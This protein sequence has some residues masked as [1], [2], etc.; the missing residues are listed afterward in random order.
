MYSLTNLVDNILYKRGAFL[1]KSIC[2]KISN[3]STTKYLLNQLNSFDFP[4]VY[5]SCKQFKIY[6]NII[7]HF[8]GKNESLFFEK[9]SEMLSFL[10]INLFEEKIIKY[11]LKSE[12]FY[13]EEIEQN[14]IANIVSEDLY[15]EEESIY[16]FEERFKIIYNSFY[17]H[18]LSNHSLF[19]KGFLTFRLKKYLETIL[20]QI[21]KS[22]N[23]F[24]V[25]KEYTEFISLL[26]MYINS[27][28]SNCNLVHLI[29][30]NYKPILLDENKNIIRID[31]NI[32]NLKYLSDIS[33]STNDFALNALLNLIPKKIYIHIIDSNIDEFINTI[34]LIFENRVVFC[35]DC[36]ICKIYK[37][38]H[39]IPN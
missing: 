28:N 19:L 26:R 8:K 6:E 5:F 31:D 11:L 3:P 14:Q 36:S 23:K 16:P 13:F 7:I 34:K 1:M 9:I 20:E 25:Q 12:Y 38:S 29:Y 39:A 24:I 15:D 35:K 4:N 37:K 17:E 18:F 27:E 22:V 30:R 10:V 21:D 2:I 32:S 33:F